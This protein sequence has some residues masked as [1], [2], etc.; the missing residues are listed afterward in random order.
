MIQLETLRALG[1]IP[2]LAQGGGPLSSQLFSLLGFLLTLSQ[3]LGIFS[4]SLSVLFSTLTLESQTLTF[5]LEHDGSHKAL[6][7][8]CF[9]LGF[10]TLLDGQRPLD[11]VLA[12]IVVL[13][14][15]KQLA[16]LWS[17]LGS[18][19][20]GN[21]V[22]GKSGDFAFALLHNDHRDDGKITIDNAAT[23]GLALTLTGTTLAVARVTLGQQKSHT[24]LGK[25]TL[26]HRKSLLVV[27]AGDAENISFPF[28]S[29]GSG[30]NLLTHALL[31]EGTY[32]NFIVDFKEFLT[33]SS[34]ESHVNLHLALICS[35]ALQR[36]RR[37]QKKK[38]K[39]N[40]PC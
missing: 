23:N 4:S 33:P 40:S 8:G 32:F 17:T 38:K 19:T 13:S 21:G 31:V 37:F 30:V 16:D 1:R 3:D 11:H 7:L 35:Q 12:N 39:E 28:I 24:S 18:Q 25:D 10:L 14:Q 26:L 15:V 29:K 27:S 6:N 5:P 9:E 22:I 34:W 2:R 20:T 36:G